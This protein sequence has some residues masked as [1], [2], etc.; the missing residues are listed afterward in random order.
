MVEPAPGFPF[1]IYVQYEV[2]AP[3]LP[4][5]ITPT[6][7]QQATHLLVGSQILL[8]DPALRHGSQIKKMYSKEFGHLSS[9][10]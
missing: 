9:K 2:R 3:L 10:H 7:Q 5:R 6:R 8:G 1:Q 4:Y